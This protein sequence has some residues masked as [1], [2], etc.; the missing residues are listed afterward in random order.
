MAEWLHGR[1]AANKILG[2]LPLWL[3]GRMAATPNNPPI[4]GPHPHTSLYASF[5]ENLTGLGGG[6]VFLID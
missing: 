3:R 4:K 5:G 2:Y 6:P 1:V